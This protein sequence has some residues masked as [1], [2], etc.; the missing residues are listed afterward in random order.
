M[1]MSYFAS[2]SCPQALLQI[3]DMVQEVTLNE[4]LI[5]ILNDFNA[6]S[7]LPPTRRVALFLD[8]VDKEGAEFADQMIEELTFELETNPDFSFVCTTRE[9]N[10]FVDDAVARSSRTVR[11][12]PVNPLSPTAS[13]LLVE[14]ATASK[15][16]AEDVA[17]L[18]AAFG[19][20]PRHFQVLQTTFDRLPVNGSFPP[21][22]EDLLRA[23]TA[24]I[25][26]T[27]LLTGKEIA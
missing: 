22:A 10:P 26:R 24:K 9:W 7:T 27:Y 11:F 25:D 12:V 23:I 14:R 17:F 1:L 2:E 19:G 16:N 5:T 18:A 21:A 3:E 4:A 20:H 6:N 13:Q 8:D 15:Y